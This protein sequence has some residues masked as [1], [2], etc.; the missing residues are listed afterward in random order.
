M[1]KARPSPVNKIFTYI[2]ILYADRTTTYPIRTKPN[3]RRTGR[4]AN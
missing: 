2:C 4:A 3:N 1:L